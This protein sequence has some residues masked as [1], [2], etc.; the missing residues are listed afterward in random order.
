MAVSATR[1]GPGGS[2]AIEATG[3]DWWRDLNSRDS[4]GPTPGRRPGR[5]EPPFAT[6]HRVSLRSGA[7]LASSRPGTCTGPIFQGFANTGFQPSTPARHL[8]KASTS[9][10]NRSVCER[11]DPM[12]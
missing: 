3:R 5:R 8:T 11:V 4:G 2:D 12:P 7:P 6:I 9:D 1:A 10:I